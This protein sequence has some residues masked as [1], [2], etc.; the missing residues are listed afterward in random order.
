MNK[1]EAYYNATPN[2][3]N[4]VQAYRSG[5]ILID[6]VTITFFYELDKMINASTFDF[7]HTKLFRDNALKFLFASL[8]ELLKE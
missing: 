3:A 6:E 7:V 2:M 8:I 4:T 1:Y 5:V